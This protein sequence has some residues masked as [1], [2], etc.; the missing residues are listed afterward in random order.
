LI[1]LLL[2]VF[3]LTVFDDT[4][5]FSKRLAGIALAYVAAATW[6]TVGRTSVPIV[7]L[8]QIVELPLA[9]AALYVVWTGREGGLVEVRL[10]SRLAFMLAAGLAVVSRLRASPTG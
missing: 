7:L 5:K 4:P 8:I 2:F 10:R 1:P 6:V 3:V 9:F